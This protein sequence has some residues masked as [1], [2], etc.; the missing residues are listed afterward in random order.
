MFMQSKAENQRDL[1]A[2]IGGEDVARRAELERLAVTTANMEGA[3]QFVDNQLQQYQQQALEV[4]ASIVATAAVLLHQG[5]LQKMSSSGSCS[6]MP[7]WRLCVSLQW[8]R[9]RRGR[10][11]RA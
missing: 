9:N 8:L 11:V 5:N 7:S 3:L 10:G 2:L 1:A 4:E 6:S